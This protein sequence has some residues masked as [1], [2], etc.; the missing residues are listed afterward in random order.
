MCVRVCI[1]NRELCTRT[2]CTSTGML[3]QHLCLHFEQSIIMLSKRCYN[4]SHFSPYTAATI[5]ARDLSVP[6]P[7]PT[8]SAPPPGPTPS[9]GVRTSA[10]NPRQAPRGTVGFPQPYPG[11]PVRGHRQWASLECCQSAFLSSLV[12]HADPCPPSPRPPGE[13]P[14][15]AQ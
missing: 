4:I 7:E 1:M 10:L 13:G 8:P 5:H 15:C 6:P 9:H 12:R 2:Q 14:P 11:S 3:C